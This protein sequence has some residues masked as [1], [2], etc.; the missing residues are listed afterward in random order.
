[1]NLRK[2]FLALAVVVSAACA[3]VAQ[4]QTTLR[5]QFTEGEKLPYVLE[6]KMNM[7]MSIA[8]MDIKTK[9][10]M[11]MEMSLNFLEKT[12]DGAAKMQIKVAHAKMTMDGPT[13]NVQVDST[14]KEE[15]NDPIGKML[16]G[17]VKGLGAMEMTATMLPTGEMKDVKVSEA[18]LKAMKNLPGADMLGD[19]ISPDSFKNMLGGLVFPTDAV[20][21]GKTWNNKSEAKTALGKTTTDNT[22]TYEGPIQKDG[23]TLEKFSVKPD[24]KIDVDPKAPVKLKVKGTKGSGQVLFDNKKGRLVET[25]TNQTTEMQIEAMGLTLD[26]TIQQTTTL[27][28]KK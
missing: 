13:G 11:T 10:D 1:M 8:G 21:K 26:Q 19:L 16:G 25:T 9:M 20:A 18:T 5:Y 3:S 23:A 6:Q 15:P 4:A 7:T 12:K 17:L 28:L 14:D 24:T 2:G 22:Y 27:R